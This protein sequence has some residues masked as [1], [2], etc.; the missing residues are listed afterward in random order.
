MEPNK[1]WHFEIVIA[2]LA[3][4]PILLFAAQRMS[5][6]GSIDIVWPIVSA[7]VLLLIAVSHMSH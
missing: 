6:P 4:I 7:V 1:R 2:A 3:S 5:G